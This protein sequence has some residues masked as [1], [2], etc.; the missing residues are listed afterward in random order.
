MTDPITIVAL[1]VSLAYSYHFLERRKEKGRETMVYC[2]KCQRWIPEKALWL[3]KDNDG[4]NRAVHGKI[5]CFGVNL[6]KRAQR[7]ELSRFE[8][9]EN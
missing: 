2:D 3:H 1:L 4:K 7:S 8:I 9:S 6:S 5:S